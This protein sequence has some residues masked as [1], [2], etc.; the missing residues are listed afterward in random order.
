MLYEYVTV[1]KSSWEEILETFSDWDWYIC[2]DIL[3]NILKD[4]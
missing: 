1:L 3:Q 4:I 2:F